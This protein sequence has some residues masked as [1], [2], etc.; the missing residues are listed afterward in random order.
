MTKVGMLLAACLITGAAWAQ[1]SAAPPGDS[2]PGVAV[3]VKPLSALTLTPVLASQG[4]TFVMVPVGMNLPLGTR[5]DLVLELTPIWTRQDCEAR[6]TGRAL[7]LAVGPSFLVA[8]SSPGSGFFL[9]P[10]LVGVL[11]QQSRETE[12]SVPGDPG[13]WS[14]TSTQLSLGLDVGYQLRRGPLFL[15]FV[16]GASVG[17]GW[18]VPAS[19]PSVF[20]SLVD[21]PERAREDKLTWDVNLHLLRV[22]ASF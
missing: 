21:W 13:S 8:P 10:K 14:E 20:F 1:P 3:W 9:Q 5:T 12:L 6:C 4:E 18:N 2:A 22:G 7:S 17:R 15:A 19:S 11:A 16:L